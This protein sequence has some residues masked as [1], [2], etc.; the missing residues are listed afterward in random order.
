MEWFKKKMARIDNEIH[1]APFP[2]TEGL[3]FD[4]QKE[5]R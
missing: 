3:L 5:F 1:R 4:Y 2:L